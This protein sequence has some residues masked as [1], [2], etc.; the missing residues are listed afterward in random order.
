M[1]TYYKKGLLNKNAEVVHNHNKFFWAQTR[2]PINYFF[3]AILASVVYQLRLD[4]EKASYF[5]T[6]DYSNPDIKNL[7]FIAIISLGADYWVLSWHA[8]EPPHPKFC[9]TIWRRLSMAI[10]IISGST[11]IFSMVT[12]FFSPQ[13]VVWEMVACC[14]ALLG[15]VPT[16]IYQWRNVF[17]VK[18]LMI[19]CYAAA[20]GTHL[21]TAGWHGNHT[22]TASASSTSGWHCTSTSG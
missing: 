7:M 12:A 18:L 20:I 1:T 15:H 16:A 10:H 19:P 2:N 8:K 22:T 9:L 14:A 6:L 21:V 13:P 3:V 5:W 4:G 11:E 17:G